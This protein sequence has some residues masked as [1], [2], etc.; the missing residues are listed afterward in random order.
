MKVKLALCYNILIEKLGTRIRQ[1]NGLDKLLIA[2]CSLLNEGA[3]EVRNMAKVGI[4]QIKNNYPS[5]R[6]LEGQLMRLISNEK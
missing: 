2:V 1:F 6:E 5:Q 3:L 4:I